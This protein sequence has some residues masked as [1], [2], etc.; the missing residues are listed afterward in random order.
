MLTK[1]IKFKQ[2][3]FSFYVI[4]LY[5]NQPELIF[6]AIKEKINHSPIFF[7]KISVIININYIKN[8]IDWKKVY[9]A[10]ISTGINIIGVIGCNNKNIIKSINNTGI[11]ILFTNNKDQKK[12]QNNDFKKQKKNVNNIKQKSIIQIIK[13]KNSLSLNK[14]IIYNKS[15]IIYNP[16]RSG[17]QI[18]AYNSDLIIINNVSTGAEL[19]ADGNIHIY[20]FMRGKALSGANG[21]K[22]CQIFCTQLFAELLSIAGE[23]LLQEQIPNKFLG[24]S[25]RIY[26]NNKVLTIK[27]CS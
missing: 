3:N 19:I 27:S 5:N 1:I 4:Y 14:N 10:I 11:P 16:I 25:S 2:N 22:N 21:D 13:E 23:Y 7:K 24:K 20:G 8:E 12:N 15:K 26:L 17:Q 9:N 6:N 18:Y